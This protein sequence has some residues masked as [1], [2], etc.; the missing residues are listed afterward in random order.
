MII[1]SLLLGSESYTGVPGKTPQNTRE[2]VSFTMQPGMKIPDTARTVLPSACYVEREEAIAVCVG[3]QDSLRA[4]LR[5]DPMCFVCGLRDALEKYDWGKGPGALQ[6]KIREYINRKDHESQAFLDVV[7]QKHIV[8]G[9]TPDR[10]IP[11][12][13]T[14]DNPTCFAQNLLVLQ[15]HYLENIAGQMYAQFR[16]WK[17]DADIYGSLRSMND[18]ELWQITEQTKNALESYGESN[19]GNDSLSAAILAQRRDISAPPTARGDLRQRPHSPPGGTVVK[20]VGTADDTPRVTE[21]DKKKKG[22][23]G[24]AAHKVGKRVS[25]VV[26]GKKDK[27][28]ASPS[29][30]STDPHVSDGSGSEQE[31]P[32]P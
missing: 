23:L 6:T 21:P 5:Q 20:I 27:S 7:V 13:L 28:V 32:L 14:G 3:F 15:K 24:R 4:I 9:D 18:R 19:I 2:E 11:S 10:H 26:S 29:A 30:P 8:T 16:S 12:A 31:D 22:L 17:L 1:L 25:A